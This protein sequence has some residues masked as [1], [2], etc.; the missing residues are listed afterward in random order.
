[1]ILKMSLDLVKRSSLNE[2]A[3]KKQPSRVLNLYQ[4]INYTIPYNT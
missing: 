2:L 4:P 1:M 3:Y